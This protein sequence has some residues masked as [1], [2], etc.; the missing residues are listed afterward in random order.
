MKTFAAIL[1]ILMVLSLCACSEK[2][3]PEAEPAITASAVAANTKETTPAALAADAQLWSHPQAV[4]AAGNITILDKFTY[5][6]EFFLDWSP[7]S[8][9]EAPTVGYLTLSLGTADDHYAATFV[10][11]GMENCA[12]ELTMEIDGEEKTFLAYLDGMG[13]VVFG[14]DDRRYPADMLFQALYAGSNISC[15]L[16]REDA[17]LSF[18]IGSGNLPDLCE[19]AGYVGG[20]GALSIK[21]AVVACLEDRKND[22]VISCLN[23]YAPD[24]PLLDDEALH[25]L[26]QDGQFIE[27]DV[28]GHLWQV[29][30]Y[31]AREHSLLWLV[32][33]D[34]VDQ[35]TNAYNR[36]FEE[37]KGAEA[38]SVPFSIGQDCVVEENSS[39]YQIRKISEGIYLVCKVEDRGEITSA[40]RL[41]FHWDSEI[42]DIVSFDEARTE[43]IVKYT[44]RI[45]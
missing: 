14:P 45:Q 25:D 17:R 27:M 22:T 19:D 13:S 7:A 10:F 16:D 30:R 4:D 24:L 8:R 29:R 35:S 6:T 37:P 33:R 42:T 34:G 26:L 44:N 1:S 40:E 21:E 32:I 2:A 20:F 41:M 9:G 23:Q 38:Q 18:V 36:I 5:I 31:S 3:A 39:T 43:I 15:T 28:T 12:A 11:P